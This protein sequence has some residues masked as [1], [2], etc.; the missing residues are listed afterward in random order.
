MLEAST[1]NLLHQLN[2]VY[3]QLDTGLFQ[4]YVKYRFRNL[5]L[6]SKQYKFTKTQ[7]V[8]YNDLVNRYKKRFV[9]DE[10]DYDP[11]SSTDSLLVNEK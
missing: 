5:C 4:W 9:Y 3:E 11:E 10:W 7:A 6:V 2:E 8:L 1:E